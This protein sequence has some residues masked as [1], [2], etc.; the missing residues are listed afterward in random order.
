M[1]PTD[2]LVI[3][4]LGAG[5]KS[6][7]SQMGERLMLTGSMHSWFP[8]ICLAWAVSVPSNA[9]AAAS[10]YEVLM[11]LGLGEKK[12]E[13]YAE[14]DWDNGGRIT[15]RICAYEAFAEGDRNA[16][17]DLGTVT[18]EGTNPKTGKA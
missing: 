17:T 7:G 10:Y 5:F 3:V 14:I 16:R 4:N 12:A 6:P 15:G 2:V 8:M 18:V 9:W 1:H 11:Y 13:G